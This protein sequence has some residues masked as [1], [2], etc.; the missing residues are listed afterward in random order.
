MGERIVFT[1]AAAS[2]LTF[3]TMVITLKAPFRATVA[4]IGTL[5]ILV[6][7]SLLDSVENFTKRRLRLP[8]S[9]FNLPDDPDE[10]KSEDLS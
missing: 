4:L 8:P 6:I 1:I 2:A 9:R 5:L 3:G 10:G 7:L